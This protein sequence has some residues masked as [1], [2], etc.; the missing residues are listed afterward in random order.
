MRA[1]LAARGRLPE[2]RPMP[3]TPAAILREIGRTALQV[4]VVAVLLYGAVLLFSSFSAGGPVL[5]VLI[6]APFTALLGL[7]VADAL[8]SGVFAQMRRSPRR[9]AQ[10][11]AYWSSVA[12]FA[13]GALLTG[14]MTARGALQVLASLAGWD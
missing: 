7:V 6:G 2:A 5:G 11:L 4:G 12:W 13:A 8:R 14:V 10:P 1:P 9:D 3:E